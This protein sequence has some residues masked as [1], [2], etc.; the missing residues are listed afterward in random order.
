MAPA[1]FL[2]DP[3]LLRTI[4][5]PDDRPKFERHAHDVIQNMRPGEL[6]LRIIL[7]DGAVRWIDH[8]CQPVFDDN[9][10]FL[11]TRGSNRDVTERRQ[12]EEA[13]RK[14]EQRFRSLL[15]T[16]PLGVLESDADGVITLTNESFARLTGYRREDILGKRLDDFFAPGPQKDDLSAYLQVIRQDQP[17]PTPLRGKGQT[18]DGRII[19]VQ[20]DWSYTRNDK[21]EVIGFVSVVSDVTERM[22]LEQMK[23]EMISAVSHEMRTPLT[24]MLGFSEFLLENRVD[25]ASVA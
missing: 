2:A 5:H 15:E 16:I 8:L 17:P 4:I 7:P 25:E 14:S 10:R 13:L 20:V 18:K 6:Q 22:A 1:E 12:A 3:D 23:D 21:G 19:D 24:A 9:G 11:G